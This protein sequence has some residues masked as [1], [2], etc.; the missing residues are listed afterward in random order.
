MWEAFW[1]QTLHGAQTGRDIRLSLNVEWQRAAEAVLGAEQGAVVL[2]TLP[3]AEIGALASHPGY[4]PNRLDEQFPVLVADED[5]PLL[6]RASQGQ[7][8]PGLTL[9]PFILAAAVEQNLVD[10]NEL[11]E[12]PNR[13]VRVHGQERQCATEPPANA[14]WEDVLQRQ[15]PYPM[16]TLAGPLDDEALTA[17]FASFGLTEQPEVPLNVAGVAD[18][19]VVELEAALIGQNALTVTP[20]QVAR[21]WAALANRGLLPAPKLVTAVQDESG[22]WQARA[23][24]VEPPQA[25]SAN[26]A[27]AIL[28]ALPRPEGFIEYATLALAGPEGNRN[29]WYL[30]LAPAGDPR[31]AV[32]VVLENSES[33]FEAQRVGRALLRVVLEP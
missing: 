8:Q 29:G 30:G 11:V 2:L 18:D 19:P 10:L 23:P 13:P 7:Y 26:A 14:T 12:T 28:A 33:V 6:N 9:Q 4:D 27:S 32:V 3:E 5:A 22:A 20:L 24:E 21:A 31:Y 16:Q 17:I 1:R 15:C 25:V